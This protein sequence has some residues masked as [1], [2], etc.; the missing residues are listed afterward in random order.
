MPRPHDP[1]FDGQPQ[2]PGLRLAANGEPPAPADPLADLASQPA[3]DP[4]LQALAWLTRHH[5]KPRSAESLRAG[6]PVEGALTPDGAIRVMREAGYNAGLLRKTIDDIHGL[7]LPAVLLLNGGDACVLVKRLDDPAAVGAGA[8]RYEVVFPGPEAAAVPATTAELEPEYSGFMLAVS[9]LETAQGARAEAPLLK[10]GDKGL[11]AHWLWGT[12]KRFTPYYR[13]SMI[14]ALLSNV[15]MLVSGL[16][17]AVIYDK[18]IPHQA[19]VTLWTLAIGAGVALLFDLFAR[20]LRA[21]LIDLAGRKADLVIGAKLYRQTLGVRMEHKPASAGSYAHYLAQVE[22]VREFFASATLSALSDL[23]FLFIFIAMT[24][25][26]GGP[27]GWVLVLAVPVIM[28][29]S[30]AIQSSLRRAMRT[31]MQETADLHGTLVESLEG[32]EDLKTSGAEGRFLRRYERTTAIVADSAM[33][34]RTLSSWSMNLSSTLQQS[35]NLILLVW[36]V[37]LIRDGQISS[38]AL[39]GSVM[40]ASRAIAPL[41]SLVS[42]ATRYQGAR[43]AMLSLNQMMNAPVERDSSRNYV[44][45]SQVSGKVGLHD[46]GFAYPA[47][48][49]L[50]AQPAAESAAPKVLRNVTMRLEAGERVAILGRIGSGKSTILRLLGGLYQPTEGMVE[51]DG[52]DLRQIDPAEYRARVGFV[53]QEP[54]LFVGTLRDNVLMGRAHLDAGRLVEV[55]KLTGLDRV[56]AGHPMGWDLPVGEMGQL[57]SGGQRQLVALAR[58]LVTKPQ[59]LLMDE[60]TSSMDA[61]SEMAFLRQLRDAAGTATLVVVTH[62]PAVLELVQRIAVVDGGRIV[63]DGPRDQVL[64]A[65][66]GVRP[67][68]PGGGTAEG[69]HL[70]PSAQPVQRSASV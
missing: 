6:A 20:Q 10:M 25:V 66:S 13:A 38:G 9:P 18:V 44:P 11:E 51:V 68:A 43:A 67:A 1:F 42:L 27:L 48:P 5:G 30:W 49:T 37:Y 7:L 70:H 23:P 4:L 41:G 24:F 52:I 63:M 62:R 60:P 12:L 61:Q 56:V 2:A 19:M 53:S 45:L 69:V 31:N 26:I 47:Q 14:A 22:M 65:L 36:G 40:F 46:V 50:G 8:C 32:L 21:H 54:R 16:V 3:G 17:T 55:A 15:L 39:I 58:A 33:T 64:A 28:G 29:L 35:V 59:V 34:A 57:L